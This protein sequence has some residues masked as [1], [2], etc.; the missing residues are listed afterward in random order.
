M[1][2][3]TGSL[4]LH[5]KGFGFLVDQDRQ[6]HFVPPPLL[7]DFF[8]GDICDADIEEESPGRTRV[9]KLN[10]VKRDRRTLFGVARKK[11]KKWLLEPDPEVST[12]TLQLNPD[13]FD[14]EDGDNVLVDL[15]ENGRARVR[16]QFYYDDQSP[17]R[18]IARIGS[19]YD[20]RLDFSTNSMKQMK[21]LPKRWS[22][23]MSKGRRDLRDLPTFTV[24]AP[25]TC[26]IDDAISVLPADNQGGVRLFVSIADATAF[27]PNESPLDLEARD[28][29]TSVYMIGHVLPMLPRDLSENRLSLLPNKDRLTLTAEM[30]IDPEGSITSLDLYESIIKSN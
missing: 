22:S 13:D 3:V 8:L 17:E 27:I 21:K 15:L 12:A 5:S 24:D 25:S 7:K 20:V 2:N 16:D 29:A 19:R 26:D 6:S 4:V 10:L 28:R 9:V 1:T 11:K 23:A 14:L 18:D 30:R